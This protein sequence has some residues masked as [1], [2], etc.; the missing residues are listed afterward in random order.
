MNLILLHWPTEGRLAAFKTL[1]EAKKAGSDAQV[2]LRWGI[3]RGII[4]P[5]SVT[6]S[7]IEDNFK[8]FDFTLSEEEMR[9]I[10]AL[11]RRKRFGPD[12]DNFNF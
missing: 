10:T 12:P 5:K 1:L 7:R 4:I 2:L 3:Q 6:P 8:L 9:Q 11:E